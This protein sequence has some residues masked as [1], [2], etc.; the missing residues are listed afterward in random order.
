MLIV[1]SVLV[2]GL[3]GG[4]EGDHPGEEGRQERVGGGGVDQ[5]GP[6]GGDADGDRDPGDQA[7]RSGPVWSAMRR[8]ARLTAE[9]IRRNCGAPMRLI[10]S[11]VIRLARVSEPRMVTTR[12]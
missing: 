8:P 9:K 12:Q 6:E 2:A 10:D 7:G 4:G 1:P 5:E 3:D 11:R